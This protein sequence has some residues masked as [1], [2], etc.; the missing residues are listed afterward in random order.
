MCQFRA[1]LLCAACSAGCALVLA[2]TPAAAADAQPPA[3]PSKPVTTVRVGGSA[4]DAAFRDAN[5]KALTRYREAARS[6]RTRSSAERRDCL[7]GARE[8]RKAAQREAKA[9]HDAAQKR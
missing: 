1:L 6:C 2:A 7:R 3:D 9:A 4:A 8:E 5:Q